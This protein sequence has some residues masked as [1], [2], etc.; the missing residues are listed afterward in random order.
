MVNWKGFGRK[1]SWHKFGVISRHSP[2]GTEQN[3]K[4]LSQDSVNYMRKQ[5]DN[6]E[7]TMIRDNVPKHAAAWR[8]RGGGA[9]GK[10]QYKPSPSTTGQYHGGI[11]KI[12]T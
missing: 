7:T 4:N 1:W 11:I 10:I 9:R 3:H 5:S 12:N 2:G 6:P 8:E